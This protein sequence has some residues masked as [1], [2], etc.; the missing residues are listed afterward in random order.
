MEDSIIRIITELEKKK[1][2]LDE[3][4]Q[5]SYNH[6]YG[7]NTIHTI[8]EK[9]TITT[10]VEKITNDDLIR[11]SPNDLST[12]LHII[13][14]DENK[15]NEI[16]LNYDPNRILYNGNTNSKVKLKQITDF[17]DDIRRNIVSYMSTYKTLDSNISEFF[18]EQR[19][20]CDK[21]IRIFKNEEDNEVLTR[22]FIDEVDAYL[23][24]SGISPLDRAN[25]LCFINDKII[26][27]ITVEKTNPEEVDISVKVSNLGKKYLFGN[28]EYLMLVSEYVDNEEIDID[29]IPSIASDICGTTGLKLDHMTNTLVAYIVGGLYSKYLETKDTDILLNVNTILKFVVPEKIELLSSAKQIVEDNKD[30]YMEAIKNNE[31]ID[32]YVDALV[33]TLIEENGLT[34]SE[35]IDKKCLPFVR[36]I[37]KLIEKM[38]TL[39]PES[40]EY[41]EGLDNINILIDLYNEQQVRKN[42]KNK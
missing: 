6:K 37:S 9:I 15:I 18:G 7:Y 20:M 34:L 11:L 22:E 10:T 17:F 40:N 24:N 3:A 39:D 28:E 19:K 38:E 23:S 32:S 5:K 27:S 16:L 13:N 35:A 4:S 21:L 14:M 33:S 26:N 2:S 30:L 31:N 12:I 41:Q 42:T 8:F 25:A 36:S 29:T 1:S